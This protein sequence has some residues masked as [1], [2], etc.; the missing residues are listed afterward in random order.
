MASI[1][2]RARRF[3]GL[4]LV[5]NVVRIRT[6]VCGWLRGA[7]IILHVWGEETHFRTLVIH[8]ANERNIDLRTGGRVFPIVETC[9]CTGRRG[10]L[11]VDRAPWNI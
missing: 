9:R 11:L 10:A 8:Q 6:A 1:V 4:T 7:R 3:C 2:Q 5:E